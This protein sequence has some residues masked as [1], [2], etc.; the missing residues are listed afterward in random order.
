MDAIEAVVFVMSRC[1]LLVP[2]RRPSPPLDVIRVVMEI[3]RPDLETIRSCS[4][5]SHSFRSVAQPFLGRHISVND[6]THTRERVR[7]AP[8]QLRVPARPF[9][10][11]SGSRVN[12]TIADVFA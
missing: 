7:S 4:L 1:R 12:R 9:A 8:E 11:V 10:L 2:T 3:V 5:V 6:P